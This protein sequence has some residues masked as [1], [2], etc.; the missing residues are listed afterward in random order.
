MISELPPLAVSPSVPDG[1]QPCPHL[2]A[3]PSIFSVRRR[4]LTAG[5]GTETTQAIESCFFYFKVSTCASSVINLLMLR[6][7]RTLKF[8]ASCVCELVIRAYALWIHWGD[9]HRTPRGLRREHDVA[10]DVNMIEMYEHLQ[11]IGSINLYS[12]IQ[13]LSRHH[14][15]RE[16]TSKVSTPGDRRA[17]VCKI[18]QGA[19]T[20]HLNECS[21]CCGQRKRVSSICRRQ[22]P[23]ETVVAFKKRYQFRGFLLT[24]CASRGIITRISSGDDRC[25][26]RRF[27]REVPQNREAILRCVL[28]QEGGDEEVSR[29]TATVRKVLL[30]DL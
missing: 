11:A 28:R 17:R 2:S 13:A 18:R 27:L 3:P 20:G 25:A 7:H 10:Y 29:E 6:G 19:R 21:G 8:S 4:E 23:H 5:T 22:A 15:V 12:F 9:S 14:H 24:V 16:I 26:R 30:L 1:A